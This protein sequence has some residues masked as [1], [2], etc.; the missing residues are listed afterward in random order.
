MTDVPL[1]IR[2]L[3]TVESVH[4][5]AE[6]LDEV[7]PGEVATMPANILRALAHSG[8]YVVGIYEGE[9]MV[10]AVAAFFGPPASRTMHSHVAGVLPA[11]QG[12]GIGRLLKDHQREW[13]FA[14]G[15]GTITWTYDP[16]VARNAHFN[17]AVLGARAT[18]YLIDQYGPMAD[19]VNRGDA[20]DRLMVSWALAQPPATSPSPASVVATVPIPPD[21]E[22]L[23]RTDPEAAAGWR[24]QL[25]KELVGQLEAGRRIAGFDR[26]LGYLVVENG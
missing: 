21:I 23:R 11:Y 10:G 18:E 4:R 22:S 19:E 12:R 20:T 13:A 5:A 14:R 7:W 9:K 15:V 1:E 2:Q 6:V 16:L 3:T 8:N 17:L 24:L 25:R 26:E